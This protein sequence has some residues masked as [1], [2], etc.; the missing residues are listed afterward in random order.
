MYNHGYGID[1]DRH[2]PAILDAIELFSIY[3]RPSFPAAMGMDEER[4]LPWCG[5]REAM[6]IVFPAAG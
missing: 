4:S 5:V 1:H 2:A 6:A 3:V